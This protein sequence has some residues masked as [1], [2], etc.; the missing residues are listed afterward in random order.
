MKAAGG[1]EKLRARLTFMPLFTVT[2]CYWFASL[3]QFMSGL[4]VCS[5]SAVLTRLCPRGARINN[6]F[7]AFWCQRHAAVLTVRLKKRE[8]ASWNFHVWRLR[9]TE[10]DFL[11]QLIFFLFSSNEPWTHLVLVVPE[12]SVTLWT[13]VTSLTLRL[14]DN[15]MSLYVTSLSQSDVDIDFTAHHSRPVDV[16]VNERCSLHLKS[17]PALN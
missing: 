8:S 16:E 7:H 4:N 15:R 10:D 2:Q 3:D 11:I 12:F 1:E 13:P 5:S 6:T 14:K 17:C 9:E